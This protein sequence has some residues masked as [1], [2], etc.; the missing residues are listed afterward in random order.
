MIPTLRALIPIILK[1]R[2]GK[3]EKGNKEAEKKQM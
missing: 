2:G 1:C 3:R